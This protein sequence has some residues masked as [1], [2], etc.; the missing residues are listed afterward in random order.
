MKGVDLSRRCAWQPGRH[1][2]TVLAD[3]TRATV[4]LKVNVIKNKKIPGVRIIKPRLSWLLEL[5]CL[6]TRRSTTPQII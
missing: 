5:I 6:W 1:E 4:Q 3:E 2:F